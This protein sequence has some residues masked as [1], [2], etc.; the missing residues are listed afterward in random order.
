MG[1]L[2]LRICN[3]KIFSIMYIFPFI[4]N[5]LVFLVSKFIKKIKIKTVIYLNKK[6][7]LMNLLIFI[8]SFLLLFQN[9]EVTKKI[10][11]L[12]YSNFIEENYILNFLE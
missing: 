4:Y 6:I 8:I 10:N 3:R 12:E 5:S 11:N 1:Y 2:I 7:T 9:L